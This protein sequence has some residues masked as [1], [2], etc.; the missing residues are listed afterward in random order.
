MEYSVFY[1]YKIWLYLCRKWSDFQTEIVDSLAIM[2]DLI[3]DLDTDLRN[4][5]VTFCTAIHLLFCWHVE[6]G[7]GLEQAQCWENAIR[8]ALMPVTP[9]TSCEPDANSK[10]KPESIREAEEK[11]WSIIILCTLG[12]RKMVM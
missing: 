3:C 12:N 8:Q 5:L 6:S 9:Q 11:V 7:I 1:F 4:I 2:F 10:A